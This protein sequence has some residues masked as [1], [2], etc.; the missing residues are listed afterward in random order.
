MGVWSPAFEHKFLDG[1]L[2]NFTAAKGSDPDISFEAPIVRPTPPPQDRGF[3]VRSGNRFRYSFEPGLFGN[4]IGADIR[5]EVAFPPGVT[6]QTLGRVVLGNDTVQFLLGFVNDGAR[7]QLVVNG[8][9]H[10]AV[11]NFDPAAPLRLQGRWH[12]HGPAQIWVN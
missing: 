6:G 11:A 1:N 8:A 12:T 10:A 9:F 4:V 3:P 2:L 7:I 5:L